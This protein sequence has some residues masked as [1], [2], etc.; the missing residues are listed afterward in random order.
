MKRSGAPRRIAAVAAL[1]LPPVIL[2]LAVDIV[3]EQFPRGLIVLAGVAIAFAAAWYGLLRTG[4]ARV[5]GVAIAV[6]ALAA[7][8]VVL[9]ADGD[10]VVQAL[11]ILAGTRPDARRDARRLQAPRPA[12]RCAAA[13]APGPLLQPEVRRR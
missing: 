9:I 11:V 13:A 2:I 12:C 5:L 4:V 8:V 6:L 1:V 10:H 3:I 7:T